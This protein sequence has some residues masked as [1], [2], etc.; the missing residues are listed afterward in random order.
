M[1]GLAYQSPVL[2]VPPV[3][4]PA[5]EFQ[6][7][8]R[9]AMWERRWGTAQIESR[10]PISH[11]TVTVLGVLGRAKVPEDYRFPYGFRLFLWF[12]CGPP[13]L[14]LLRDLVGLVDLV[15]LVDLVFQTNSQ[16]NRFG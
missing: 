8:L 9:G 6:A 3:P 4:S 2:P 13:F 14:L 12:L 15:D 7:T 16:A 5:T 10:L 1:L 11:L